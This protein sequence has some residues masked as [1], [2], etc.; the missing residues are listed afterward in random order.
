IF[1]ERSSLFS[2][3]YHCLKLVKH[4]MDDYITYA[5]IVNRECERFKLASMT[6]TQFKCLMFICGLQSPSDADIRTRLL[7]RLEQ[8]PDITLQ[9]MAEECQ[10]LINLKHDSRMVEQ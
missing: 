6:E 4:S 1:G 7:T 8:D 10:R 2:T 9:K 3:R 5:G